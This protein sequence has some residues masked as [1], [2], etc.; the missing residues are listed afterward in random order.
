MKQYT[1]ESTL[2]VA[3]RYNNTKR[4]YLLVNPLQAKHIPVSPTLALEMMYTL[5]ENLAVKYPSTKLVI[6]FAETATAIGAAVASCLSAD[7]VYLHTTREMLEKGTK[8]LCF[9]EEHSH[10]VEQKL[11]GECLKDRIARTDTVLLVEDEISTGKTIVNMIDQMKKHYPTLADKRIVAASILNRVSDENMKIMLE[12]GI[13]CEYLVKLPEEDYSAFVER[14]SVCEANTVAESMLKDIPWTAS[15][16]DKFFDPRLGVCVEEYE[17]SLI[18]TANVLC[19]RFEN[20]LK[21]AESVL[22]LGTEECMYPALKLGYTMEQHFPNLHIQCHATTRSPIGI[23]DAENY[24]IYC[25]VKLKSLYDENRS[26]YLY[27]LDCYDVVFIVTD[28]VELNMNG[29]AQLKSIFS[30]Y[31]CERICIIKGRL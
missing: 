4:T 19:V 12:N 20:V 21:S 30:D 18:E 14:Y 5:G 23:S 6:G 8:V 3:K 2:R 7:C 22:V 11:C 13:E 25:G 17:Q 24:P 10:A 28:A 27:N 29:V 9:Q 1:V 15:E 26:T 31:G 16:W